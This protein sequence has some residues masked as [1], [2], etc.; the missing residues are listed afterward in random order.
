M[1]KYKIIDEILSIEGDNI[2]TFDEWFNDYKVSDDCEPTVRYRIKH[3]DISPCNDEHISHSE[4]VDK[5]RRE[6]KT[7]LQYGADGV[8]RMQIVHNDALDDIEFTLTNMVEPVL[9]NSDLEYMYM[10]SYFYFYML[11]RDVIMFHSSG[12]SFDGQGLLFTAPSGTGKSTHTRL[13]QA[14]FG[15][16]VK[17][18]NDD[19]PAVGCGETFMTYG[20]PFSGKDHINN[21]ISAPLKAIVL[22]DRAPENSV[23]VLNGVA[24]THAIAEEILRP[25]N[26]PKLMIQTLELVDKVANNVPC[27]KL[28]CTPTEEAVDVI[29]S[30][31]VQDGVLKG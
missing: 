21:N 2:E 16:R 15:D 30:R 27:Y 31:L 26:N 29:Y 14:K 5:Y 22:I 10:G 8:V 13:W 7:T 19:K 4:M 11:R 23:S 1:P 24:K 18:I 12:L 28:S 25:F 20:T 17:M 9:S 6:D 3:G